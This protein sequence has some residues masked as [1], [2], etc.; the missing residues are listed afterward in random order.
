[1]GEVAFH[2]LFSRLCRISLNKGK[3]ISSLASLNS[4]QIASWNLSFSR[5]FNEREFEEF[6]S[7]MNIIEGIRLFPG[8][9]D[10]RRWL[11]KGEG[12]SCSSLFKSL[13]DYPLDP[14]F[15][16]SKL[17]WAAGIPT[18]VQVF[19]WLVAHGRV[20]TCDLL[21][22]RRPNYCLSPSW[23]VLCKQNEETLSHILLHCPYSYFIWAKAWAEFNLCWV[24]PKSGAELLPMDINIDG[25]IPKIRTLWRCIKVAVMWMIWIERNNRIFEGKEEQRE[26]LWERIRFVASLWASN[27]KSFKHCGVEYIKLNW[28]AI[29]L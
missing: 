24:L 11:L 14:Y 28:K 2:S 29:I 5:S 19:T 1:M 6:V 3:S 17:I 7:L 15:T 10:K 27:S 18:K 25:D 16:P 9:K 23:C 20:N 21:Q 8:C 13:I 22:K 12:F 4:N 26:W